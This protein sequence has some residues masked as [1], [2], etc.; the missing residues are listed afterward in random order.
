MNGTLWQR[1]LAR[2]G[3]WEMVVSFRLPPGRYVRL[4]VDGDDADPSAPRAAD[5][6]F[7]SP[8]SVVFVSSPRT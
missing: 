7:G 4:V 8:N 2:S 1:R 3:E 5:D 6:D